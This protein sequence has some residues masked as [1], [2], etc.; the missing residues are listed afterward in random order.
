LNLNIS[1]SR[2]NIRNLVA[3]FGPIYVEN[4]LAKFQASRF[5]GVGGDWGD[6]RTRYVK[7]SKT[8]PYTKFLNSFLPFGRDNFF[9]FI[10]KLDIL[11]LILLLLRI[12]KAHFQCWLQIHT[13][14][15]KHPDEAENVVIFQIH[16]KLFSIITWNLLFKTLQM[17]G[18][19][20]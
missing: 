15:R 8:D 20:I 13:W 14:R 18:K 9:Q 12:F 7:H 6:R 16:T 11:T 2:Q 4:M 5:T 17:D 1:A 3:N 10:L 19:N